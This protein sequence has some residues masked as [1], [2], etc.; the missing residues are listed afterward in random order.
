MLKRENYGRR[1]GRYDQSQPCILTEWKKEKE[2]AREFVIKK[3]K[4]GRSEW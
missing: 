3:E 4:W 2:R 1:N